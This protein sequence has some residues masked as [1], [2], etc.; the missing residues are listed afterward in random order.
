[1]RNCYGIAK[2]WKPLKNEEYWYRS[3]HPEVF[4][5]KGVVIEIS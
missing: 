3:S 4:C 1:M 2:N 5:K